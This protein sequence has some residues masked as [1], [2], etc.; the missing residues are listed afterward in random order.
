MATKRK[1][2]FE[3]FQRKQAAKRGGKLSPRTHNQPPA[4]RLPSLNEARHVYV[5]TARGAL[6]ALRK[7]FE[8]WVQVGIGLK[9]L[10]D[11]ADELGGKKTYDRLREREG[12]GRDV[13]NKSRSSRLLAIIDKLSEVEGWRATLTDNQRFEWASPEAVHRH[14]PLFAKP[15]NKSEVKPKKRTAD[16]SKARGG[17]DELLDQVF[18]TFSGMHPIEML[19]RFND[20]SA[21]VQAMFDAKLSGEK[22]KKPAGKALLKEAKG[23]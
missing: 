7:T 18:E 13:I 5:E 15:S 2:S 17:I 22:A 21:K 3:E 20:F 12:L 6:A 14:C 10:H 4:D 8:T 1:D 16:A 19:N 23:R 9:A 11:L